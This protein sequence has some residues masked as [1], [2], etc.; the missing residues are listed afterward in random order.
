MRIGERD[1]KRKRIVVRLDILFFFLSCLLLTVNVGWVKTVEC[2]ALLEDK[3]RGAEG[4][5][6]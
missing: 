3:K 1:R 4:G 6:R 2:N 5:K